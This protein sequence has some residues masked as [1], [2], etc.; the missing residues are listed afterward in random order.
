[1]LDINLEVVYPIEYIAA[2]IP[3]HPAR[4]NILALSRNLLLNGEI[5]SQLI[6]NSLFYLRRYHPIEIAV[7]IFDQAVALG[8]GQLQE[9]RMQ[10][11]SLVE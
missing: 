7:A 11:Q 2:A 9:L 10:E 5:W 3:R 4:E 8:N 6:N 1:M